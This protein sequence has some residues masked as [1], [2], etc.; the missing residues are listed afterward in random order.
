MDPVVRDFVRRRADH[1]CEYC[2]L[3]Q[4]AVPFAPFHIE[5]I[6]ARQHGGDD[7]PSNLALA[8]DRC[9]LYKGPNLAGIDPETGAV[10]V[11]FHPRRDSWDDH[12]RWISAEIV[13]QTPLGRATVRLLQ[14]NSKRRVQLRARFRV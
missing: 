14:M 10:T 2:H 5:H 13:G 8:C 3:P 11:L 4:A 9:N 6:V 12:F 7:D 1:R